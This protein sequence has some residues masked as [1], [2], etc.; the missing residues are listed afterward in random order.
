[1]V[2][3]N[4]LQSKSYIKLIFLLPAPSPPLIDIFFNDNKSVGNSNTTSRID[5]PILKLTQKIAIS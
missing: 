2:L 1:M 5:L 3:N 4:L